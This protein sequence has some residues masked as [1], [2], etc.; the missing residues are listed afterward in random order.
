[1][2]QKD[3]KQTPILIRHLRHRQF[4]PLH[5]IRSPYRSPRIRL[6]VRS[7]NRRRKIHYNQSQILRGAKKHQIRCSIYILYMHLQK[8]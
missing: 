8:S 6:T 2:V 4:L 3:S 5:I 7:Y 1:M